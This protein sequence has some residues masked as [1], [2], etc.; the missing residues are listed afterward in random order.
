MVFLPLLTFLEPPQYLQL[1]LTD[2][3]PSDMEI[4]MAQTPKKI[5]QIAAE[6][7]LYS[8]EIE[9]YGHYKAKGIYISVLG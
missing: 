1:K 5:S 7:G 4:A 6:L 9:E 8:S 2:P 3:V